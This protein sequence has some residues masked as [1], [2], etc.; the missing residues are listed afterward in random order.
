MTLQSVTSRA[1]SI[2][3]TQHS[4]SGGRSGGRTEA[5][6]KAAG[7]ERALLQGLVV[8]GAHDEGVVHGAVLVDEGAQAD[9]GVVDARAGADDAA[10]AQDAVVHLAVLHLAG[11]QEARH[12]VDRRVPV[13]EAAAAQW[14]GLSIGLLMMG[15]AS[16]A[17]MM[18]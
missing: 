14:T 12:R 13:V 17:E 11:R 1:T 18:D 8:V 5:H 7:H 6:G 2:M 3:Y 10:V 9:D 15:K 16:V 4:W